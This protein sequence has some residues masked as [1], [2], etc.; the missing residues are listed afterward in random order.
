[1]AVIVALLGMGGLFAFLPGG[2]RQG[3]GLVAVGLCSVGALLAFVAL[4]AGVQPSSLSLPVGPPGWT[5]RLVLDPLSAFFLVFLFAGYAGALCL[6]TASTDA[7]GPGDFMAC[8]GSA[9]GL[10]L[11]LLAGDPTFL[12]LG[13]ALAG[14]TLHFAEEPVSPALFAAMPAAGISVLAAVA[15]VA[16]P[17]TPL[18]L[19]ALP[20]APGSE[21]FGT[22]ALILAVVGAGSLTAIPRVRPRAAQDE[23]A[24]GRAFDRMA[25]LAPIGLY[26]FVR[27]LMSPVGPPPPLW[28]AV[29]LALAGAAAAVLAPWL[30]GTVVRMTAVGNAMTG[31]M[32]G[33]AAIGIGLALFGR[34][35]DLPTLTALALRAV[36]LLAA[37]QLVTGVLL[38]RCL[39][40]IRQ[41]AGTDRM[42]RL[43]GLS[44]LMPI[45][46]LVL[47]IGTIGL[48]G[49]PFGFS[50]AGTWLLFQ[51]LLAAPRMG[52]LAE[53]LLLAGLATSLAVSTALAGAAGVRMLGVAC[54]GRTRSPRAS[55]ATDVAGRPRTVLFGLAA[56]TVLLGGL[57]GLV[58]HGLGAPV[59]A[60]LTGTGPESG[61]GVLG[62]TAGPDVSAYLVLPLAALVV[63]CGGAAVWLVGRRGATERVSP[64]WN[65]GFAPPP[66]WMPMGDPL[67]QT[68]GTGFVPD[69]PALP[70]WRPARRRL[71]RTPAI[72][73]G[74]GGLWVALAVIA[75]L[76]ASLALTGPA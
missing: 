44:H 54:L 48:A 39:G 19:S 18:A 26:L 67:S 61:G 51:G 49:L 42:D 34:S 52:G 25:A 72:A 59:V 47:G 33:L 36:L 32:T 66:H 74:V 46:T 38:V 9:V 2:S 15:I 30:A 29:T 11:A 55:A 13:L 12:V 75:C 5:S 37:G 53:Q 69:L 7:D 10:A 4:V 24:S 8:A 71:L 76:L 63:L 3:I 1:L 27:L 68:D 57:P 14:A 21:W 35:A 58:L 56:L 28:L 22:L 6:A 60:W 64:A 65:D 16:T 23:P 41:A 17:N 45:V 73:M 70:R 43:G 31:R 40:A 20:V 50:F 62:L